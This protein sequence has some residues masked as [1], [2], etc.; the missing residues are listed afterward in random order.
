MPISFKPPIIVYIHS[1]GVIIMADE[2]TNQLA[3]VL[4]FAA[5]GALAHMV[6]LAQILGAEGSFTLF[7]A[8]CAIPVAFIGFLPGLMA[9]L[10]A[11]LTAVLYLGKPLDLMI[12][13]R[14]LPP[15]AAGAFFFAYK[16]STFS[17]KLS[18]AM[19]YAIP[20]SAMMLFISHP[21]IL[22]TQAMIYPAFW[23]IPIAVSRM[24]KNIL[25]RSLGAT[26]TQHAVGSVIFLYAIPAL[27][28]P[29]IWTSLIPIVA[30]ERTIF[31]LGIA[32][33]YLS[34]KFVPTLANQINN[35]LHQNKN[36]QMH[37]IKEE[38]N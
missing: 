14:L 16:N 19:H 9:I 8:M 1:L 17:P 31:T 11:K 10:I 12:I 36:P 26:F 6:P 22:G 4:L 34:I 32:F 30:I 38:D 27:A 20:I 28:N 35:A 25:L 37:K 24:P 29:A 18:R 2:K 23:L 21:A 13:A 33:T 7:D 15:I 3:F 5:G